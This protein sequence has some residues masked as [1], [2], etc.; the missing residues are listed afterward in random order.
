[1]GGLPQGRQA[2]RLAQR[3]GVGAR[4]DRHHRLHDGLRHDRH[5]ADFSLVKF[6]K[7]VGGSS[8]R[9]STRR[10]ARCVASAPRRP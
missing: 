1:V 2:E 5:R 8:C 4:T 7:L 6:K 3:S 10:P 9:S